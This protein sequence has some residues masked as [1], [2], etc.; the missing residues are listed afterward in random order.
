M[1]KFDAFTGKV[2]PLP[3]KDIDTDMI[4][5]A[6]YLTSIDREG[7]GQHLFT[8]LKSMDKN[9]PSNQTR[10]QNAE[11]IIADS[12]FGC[13]SSREH[14]VWA[15]QQ[16]GFK[17]IIAPSFSDIFFNNSTKNGLLL[18]R[19]PVSVIQ[20]WLTSPPELLTVDLQNQQVIT[21]TGENHAFDY[22]PFRKH[23]LLQGQ[24]DLDYLLAHTQEI[25]HHEKAYC[26]ISR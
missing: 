17:V 13:G 19:L 9:F 23:C 7:Y 5:P 21:A 22:D 25:A 2:M 1:K 16:G 6:Q 15:L 14:A 8:R 26:D 10:Y 3:I 12:N 24:D 4:I 18:I 11:I 20:Q